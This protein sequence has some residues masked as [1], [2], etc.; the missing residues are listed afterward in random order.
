MR[1]VVFVLLWLLVL[2][3]PWEHAFA[4]ESLGSIP[5]ILGVVTIA[6][7]LLTALVGD[8]VRRLTGTHLLML[9][10]VLWSGI[11]LFWSVNPVASV[12]RLL[13]MVQLLGL[14]WLVWEFAADLPGQLALMEAYVLGCVVCI[15]GTYAALVRHIDVGID[16]YT[17]IGIDP[18]DLAV[19]L[20]IGI[21]IAWYLALTRTG[22]LRVLALRL[23]VFASLVIV[24][25]TGSR[26]GTLASV[27]ALTVLLA[28]RRKLSLAS[29][30]GTVLAVGTAAVIAIMVVPEASWER[31]QNI[32][33]DLM[34]GEGFETRRGILENGMRAFL[35][36]PIVGVGLG[37]FGAATTGALA[38]DIVAHNTLLS[39][40]VETGIV[41]GV[42]F[43][44]IVL[45]LILATRGM[46]TLERRVWR[47]CLLAWGVGVSTLTWEYRK[48]TWVLFA[49]ITAQAMVW[50]RARVA[51][52][53][54]AGAAKRAVVAAPAWGAQTRE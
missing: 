31:M 35:Q 12:T 15:G 10:Y 30:V 44:A 23:F 36:D 52:R 26:G 39:V 43:L 1:K 20:A 7:A 9:I 17:A 29:H 21:P 13:T 33:A 2:A 50:R 24:L 27:A 37:A 18:N 5:R 22:R 34:G 16:R 42:A 32:A 3:V 41:G 46:P 4:I 25:L 45:A 19:T 49:L 11:S 6:L 38:K 14:V 8:T 48:V 53:A 28:T 51:E 40:L 54:G 47:V